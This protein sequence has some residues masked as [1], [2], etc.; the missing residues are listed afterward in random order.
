VTA[1]VPLALWSEVPGPLGAISVMMADEV[2]LPI[3]RRRCLL[4]AE[5]FD[6]GSAGNIG[7]ASVVTGDGHVWVSRS[8]GSVARLSV[9]NGGI[10][11]FSYEA[12]CA[13]MA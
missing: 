11:T 3:D 13:D 10:T 7:T 9:S 2:C 8:G 12:D 6:I 1:D 5:E 4:L